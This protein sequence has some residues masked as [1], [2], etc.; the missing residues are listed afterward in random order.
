MGVVGRT[1]SCYRTSISATL[2]RDQLRAEGRFRASPAG[3]SHRIRQTRAMPSEIGR[4]RVA[5]VP[6][7]HVVAELLD[8]F[9]R[10]YE[11]PTPGSAVLAARLERL[12]SGRE[13]VALLVGEPAVAVALLTLRPNVWCGGAVALLDELYVVPAERWRGIGA[14][15]LKA[16]E[17]VARQRGSELLEINVDGEDTDARRFYERYGYAN[18]DPGQTQPQLC[19]HRDLLPPR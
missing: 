1:C 11:T 19:C 8:R 3:G 2:G 10:E 17:A 15:L 12:L 6:E 5:T 13:V 9:N 7:A 18:H 14:A 4:P 16:A